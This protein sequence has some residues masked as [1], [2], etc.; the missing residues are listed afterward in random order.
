MQTCR[1][2]LKQTPLASGIPITQMMANSYLEITNKQVD[3]E[4]TRNCA[5]FH[6]L[7]FSV[8]FFVRAVVDQLHRLRQKVVHTFEGHQRHGDQRGDALEKFGFSSERLCID[9]TN[10]S[11]ERRIPMRWLPELLQQQGKSYRSSQPG[12]PKASSTESPLSAS[13]SEAPSA[14]SSK[15]LPARGSD[16]TAAHRAAIGVGLSGS[17]AQNARIHC[18]ALAPEQGSSKPLQNS[19]VQP[20]GERVSSV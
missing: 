19:L 17:I 9:F 4:K 5:S 2:C 13:S 15:A 10:P 18:A 3:Y 1:F 6:V 20:E 14:S 8:D 11:P 16:S 7:R 12:V